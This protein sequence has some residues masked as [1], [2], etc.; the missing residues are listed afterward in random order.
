MKDD[1]MIRSNNRNDTSFMI[2]S[3]SFISE[4]DGAS[5]EVGLN[6]RGKLVIV[7]KEREDDDV[8]E[9]EEGDVIVLTY[10]PDAVSPSRQY[11]RDYEVSVN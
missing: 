5:I 6:T 1:I 7:E 8:Y 3:E 2:T 10:N 11:R 9:T 4:L